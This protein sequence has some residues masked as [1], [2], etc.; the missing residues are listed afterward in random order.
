MLGPLKQT[1][2][3][4]PPRLP[5]CMELLLM[6]VC[7]SLQVVMAETMLLHLC[8]M[9]SAQLSFPS[10][11]RGLLLCMCLLGFPE[12]AL[13]SGDLITQILHLRLSLCRHHGRRL[14][15]LS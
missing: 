11:A 13:Q 8:L 5:Y 10:S 14:R 4:V 1:H 7:Q 9:G 15:P 3:L 6:R 2:N 12:L